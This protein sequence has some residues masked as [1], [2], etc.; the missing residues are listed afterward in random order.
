MTKDDIIDILI[1]KKKEAIK[2]SDEWANKPAS[3]SQDKLM[4]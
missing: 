2:Y 4:N 1:R 3:N